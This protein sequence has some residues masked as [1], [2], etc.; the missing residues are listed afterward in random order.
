MT[1]VPAEVVIEVVY[2]FQSE[3]NAAWAAAK[4]YGWN[5]LDYGAIVQRISAGDRTG[6]A[7]EE[8]YRYFL[9]HGGIAS[10]VPNGPNETGELDGRIEWRVATLTNFFGKWE[11][12]VGILDVKDED[13]SYSTQH[14]R[15]LKTRMDEHNTCLALVGARKLQ[16]RKGDFFNTFFLFHKTKNLSIGLLPLEHA[17]G[18]C[19]QHPPLLILR[20]AMGIARGCNFQKSPQDA[21]WLRGNGPPT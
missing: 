4:C 11:D 20:R 12:F 2:Q 8:L 9:K 16:W 14:L 3:E 10:Y 17:V 5:E 15:V 7:M 19:A 18:A 13:S 1:E 21:S 6:K